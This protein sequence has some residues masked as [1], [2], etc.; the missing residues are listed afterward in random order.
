[1]S[2]MFAAREKIWKGL[3]GSVGDQEGAGA[4]KWWTTCSEG[5]RYYGPRML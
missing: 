5:R 4:D 1:M 3:T 2:E